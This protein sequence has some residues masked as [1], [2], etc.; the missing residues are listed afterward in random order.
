MAAEL[1]RAEGLL[2]RF[3][4]LQ[5]KLTV[6]AL[7][8]PHDYRK[9]LMSTWAAAIVA[10]NLGLSESAR[11]ELLIAALVRDIGL[12]HIDHAIVVKHGAFNPLEWRT[13]RSHVLIGKL[14][15]KQMNGIPA[16]LVRAVAEHHEVYDGTGYLAGLT[17]EQLG[18]PGQII[19]VTDAMMSVLA[20]LRARGRGPRDLLPILRINSHMHHPE[21]CAELI[22]LLR[23]LG[24]PDDA[25]TEDH[26]I[27]ALAQTVLQERSFLQHYVGCLGAAVA[28]AVQGMS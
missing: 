25:I 3:P 10:R 11:D 19:S 4:I 27:E 12:L 17:F 21:V 28:K 6:L 26:S 2:G 20:R 23:E 15:L 9:T 24:L 22:L 16:A 5:Q 7:Q 1:E 13:M 8:L 14:I 18:L